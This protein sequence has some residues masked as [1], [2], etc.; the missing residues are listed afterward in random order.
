MNNTNVYELVRKLK[1]KY[2]ASTRIQAEQRECDSLY[3]HISEV[4]DITDYAN[5]PNLKNTHPEA[6]ILKEGD[7]LIIPKKWWHHVESYNDMYGCNFWTSC[8]LG[9][10][11]LILKHDIEFN[12][13]DL[14]DED[15]FVWESSTDSSD[16]VKFSEY[17]KRK[18]DN[19]YLW[20][21]KDYD[22][23]SKNNHLANKIRKKIKIPQ[24]IADTNKN[25][26]FNIMVC[27]KSHS[28]R[29]HYDDEDGL[30]CV[31]KGVKKVIMFPPED[32]E[33]LYPVKFERYEWRKSP[34]IDCCYNK[35]KKGEV[36]SG[37]SSASLLFQT[38]KNKPGILSSISKI[39]KHFHREDATNK[40][41]W[42]YKKNNDNYSWELYNYEN[43]VHNSNAT[44][45]VIRSYEIFNDR[46]TNGRYISNFYDDYFV[47]KA[48]DNSYEGNI[49]RVCDGKSSK[50]GDWVFDTQE[51]FFNNFPG[52]IKQ[53]HYPENTFESNIINKYKSKYICI[54]QKYNSEFYIQYICIGKKE[55][56]DFLKEHNYDLDLIN[57]Y[58]N[59]EYLI[60]NEITIVYDLESK[61]IVRT[62]FYG[63]V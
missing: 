8:K 48:N 39:I 15:I 62:A 20:T 47:T 59:E 12:Y 60:S 53:L 26:E 55:F 49:Y 61:K 5:F 29:L 43:K 19:E 7:A 42:G 57:H 1:L 14:K 45:G 4:R 56:L 10:R 22:L 54:H 30:L 13:D 37:A 36:I 41:V 18:K 46:D 35:Y 38:C 63:I 6:F 40:T 3:G 16:C 11:P 50:R 21:L 32:T 44:D 28:T 52:Y 33:N 17:I 24:I 2:D 58:E 51:N 34:A 9:D 25:F 27:S 23:L 31:T